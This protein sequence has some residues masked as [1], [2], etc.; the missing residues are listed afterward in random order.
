[1]MVLWRNVLFNL[2]V[3][4][5]SPARWTGASMT[6]WHGHIDMV[7][8]CVREASC[9][10]LTWTSPVSSVAANWTQITCSFS[11]FVT[12]QDSIRSLPRPLMFF[13][14]PTQRGDRSTLTIQIMSMRTPSNLWTSQ[15]FEIH[16]CCVSQISDICTRDKLTVGTVMSGTLQIFSNVVSKNIF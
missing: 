8:A 11:S 6:M 12:L 15:I 7:A 14:S 5:L 2:L 3:F 16:H 1:M 4:L 13:P 10:K 9:A